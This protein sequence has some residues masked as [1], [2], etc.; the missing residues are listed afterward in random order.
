MAGIITVNWRNGCVSWRLDV[1]ARCE[2]AS[3][4][5]DAV[6]IDR[7]NAITI[8][9]SRRITNPPTGKHQIIS[10]VRSIL[11]HIGTPTGLPGLWR[12]LE[13]R[14][15]GSVFGSDRNASP[16]RRLRVSDPANRS[17]TMPVGRP[18]NRERSNARRRQASALLCVC[19]AEA[20][21]SMIEADIETGEATP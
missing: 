10:R 17:S 9:A 2:A 20:A 4:R 13:P 11:S 16:H 15:S 5:R 3:N 6:P 19:C 14:V 18:L 7:E 8:Q 1:G 12:R 21:G